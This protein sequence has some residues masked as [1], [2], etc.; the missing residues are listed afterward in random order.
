MPGFTHLQ[1]A[2]PVTLGH[3]LLAYAEMLERDRSRLLDCA[4][5][6]NESPLG[7]AALAGTGFPIDR[8]M[9][10][11]ALGFARPMANSLDAV[12]SRDFAL[13]A[14]STLSIAATHL[15]R[16]AEEI[17]TVAQRLKPRIVVNKAANAYE[18][19]IACN[20]LNKYVRQWLCVEPENLGLIYFDQ[21]VS[22]AVNSGV[23]FVAARPQ[24]R[25]SS[26]VVEL[27][28]RLGY[29]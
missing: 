19:K 22:E 11:E 27:A 20:I 9:T 21:Y 8:D 5:R 4:V 10:A 28:N 23:P 1:T 26:C 7:A 24:L 3:H 18:A 16:L 12:G 14:L 29:L 13:E 15:S 6:L 25:I 17:V 2:Q